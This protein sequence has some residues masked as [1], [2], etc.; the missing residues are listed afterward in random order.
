MPTV[1]ERI[2]AAE[3]DAEVLRRNAAEAAREAI[4]DAEEE[5]AASLHIAREEAKA[6]LALAQK[7]AE[8]EAKSKASLLRATR[9]AEADSV[10]AEANKHMGKAVDR[11]IERII[12]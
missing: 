9:E 2:A 3:A 1:I 6:E 12:K 11:I 10:I 8:G 7:L 4:A 5:A